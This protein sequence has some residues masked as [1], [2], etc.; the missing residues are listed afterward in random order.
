RP[1][2]CYSLVITLIKNHIALSKHSVLSLIDRYL[3]RLH[4]VNAVTD[5]NIAGMY[6]D[7]FPLVSFDAVCARIDNKLITAALRLKGRASA[8][9]RCY[10][11]FG[12]YGI[13]IWGVSNRVCDLA[14]NRV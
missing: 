10:I 2:A 3:V 11:L 13:K 8:F 9:W 7:A 12:R 6:N 14:L 5:I 4:P 1:R